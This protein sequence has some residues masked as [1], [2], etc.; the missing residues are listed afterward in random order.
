MVEVTESRQVRRA[1]ARKRAFAALRAKY[2][3]AARSGLRKIARLA[4]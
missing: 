4:Q 2:P 1:N 3:Q